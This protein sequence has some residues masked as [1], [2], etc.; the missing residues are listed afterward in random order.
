MIWLAEI[1]VPDVPIATV[2]QMIWALFD[3]PDGSDRPFLYRCLGNRRYLVLSRLRPR[4][5]CWSIETP[6]AGQTL[7]FE[8]EACAERWMGNRRKHER[9]R[10]P[11]DDRR[12][13]RPITDNAEL[14]KWIGARLQGAQVQFAHAFNRAPLRFV[15]V[16]HGQQCFART[17]F[18]GACHVI[19]RAA[20]ERSLLLGAGRGKYC[21]LGL[22][23]LPDVMQR[24]AA[25]ARTA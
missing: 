16:R 7:T 6:A 8:V 24:P 1:T 12:G 9:L 15:H 18:V 10:G 13:R 21:G 3:V 5:A 2:H 11:D 22:I 14:Q 23:Y 17:R 25:L 19:D 4:A 20:F